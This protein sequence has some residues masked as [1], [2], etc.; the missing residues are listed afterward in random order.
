MSCFFIIALENDEVGGLSIQSLLLV[1]Q[2]SNSHFILYTLLP[3][4]APRKLDILKPNTTFSD[5]ELKSILTLRMEEDSLFIAS[6]EYTIRCIDLET[7]QEKYAQ[8][9]IRVTDIVRKLEY[10]VSD[11]LL[12]VSSGKKIEVS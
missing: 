12:Y 1:T 7:M 2:S 11:K 9:P 8:R 10:R 3:H 6:S 4:R 5:E